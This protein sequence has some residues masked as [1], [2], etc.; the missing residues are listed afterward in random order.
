MEE[1]GNQERGDEPVLILLD[2]SD[3][4][5]PLVPASESI[6]SMKMIDG[7]ASRAISNSCLTSLQARERSTVASVNSSRFEPPPP[8]PSPSIAAETISNNSPLRLSH[9]LAHKVTTTNAEERALRLGRDG[10]REETLSRPWRSVKKDALPWRPLAGE[11]VRKL[12]G[13]D[14]G[15]LEG[16]LG[17]LETGDVGPEDVRGFREDGA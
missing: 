4:P 10:L 1:Q 17:L 14:D 16:L 7:L 2:A 15:F 13:K 8:F 11:E 6:S 5:S 3:S 9:P 12:D